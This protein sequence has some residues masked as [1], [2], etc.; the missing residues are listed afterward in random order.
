MKGIVAAALLT[1]P[2]GSLA[3]GDAPSPSSRSIQVAWICPHSLAPDETQVQAPVHADLTF[4]YTAGQAGHFS[5]PTYERILKLTS[6]SHYDYASCFNNL[7]RDL[8]FAIARDCEKAHEQAGTQNKNTVMEC[9]FD[10]FN[11]KADI[12]DQNASHDHPE[13]GRL[14]LVLPLDK[15]SSSLQPRLAER[16]RRE[17]AGI[18]A[19]LPF[20]KQS[21]S[22]ACYLTNGLD[23]RSYPLLT[24]QDYVFDYLPKFLSKIDKMGRN[25]ALSNNQVRT[26]KDQVL[27]SYTNAITS[28]LEP[29]SNA[30]APEPRCQ[31][32]RARAANLLR[33]LGTLHPMATQTPALLRR[34]EDLVNS[35]AVCLKDGSNPERLL[36]QFQMELRQISGCV[37][38]LPGD[39]PATISG[40]RY[41]DTS[42]T[43]AYTLRRTPPEKP[44]HYVVGINLV[45][46]PLDG[47]HALMK[48]KVSQCLER[49]NKMLWQKNG[50]TMEIQF[51]L[52]APQHLISIG[53]QPRE[54]SGNWKD[55]TMPRYNKT[56][57]CEINTHEI[58]HVLG[59]ADEYTESAS[60]YVVDP[61]QP[62]K[63][64]ER[65]ENCSRTQLSDGQK[66]F[67]GYDC[68]VH[69]P[70]SS[71]MSNSFEAFWR[72]RKKNEP[73]LFPAQWRVITRPGCF[74]EN[75]VAY[76]CMKH[77]Y[78]TSISSGGSGCTPIE[79]E[80]KP[81][82]DQPWRFLE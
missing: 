44:A 28:L 68:R 34:R 74:A 22:M 43:P 10:S 67:H 38:P 71:L 82:Q 19:N 62:E 50:E 30:L 15:L 52:R 54:N 77:A 35:F 64:P 69:G 58:F 7:S 56:D 51:D 6:Q 32:M 72:A 60:G 55:Q 53:D 13:T 26:C 81:T 14:P 36:R 48:Q 46:I 12:R 79:P 29:C 76:A 17:F 33:H 4:E 75:K 41:S 3:Y 23:T 21:N 59:L 8:N 63:Q 47:R 24:S 39:P 37:M 1:M 73:L 49:V 2:F 31:E 42:V 11:V 18:G 25:G 66:C 45:F 70:E 27:F 20:S 61:K 40:A 78:E 80:C 5:G 16:L 65:V 57:F 9:F